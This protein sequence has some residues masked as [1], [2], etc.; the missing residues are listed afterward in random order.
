MPEMT[1]YKKKQGVTYESGPSV[2]Y[3][4]KSHFYYKILTLQDIQFSSAVGVSPRTSWS[5]VVVPSVG[6]LDIVVLSFGLF[7]KYL[8]LGEKYSLKMAQLTIR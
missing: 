7:F 2:W 5:R 8:L 6:S 1:L 4:H 3:H